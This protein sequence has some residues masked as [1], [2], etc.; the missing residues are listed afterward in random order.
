VH[1]V[2]L[3]TILK[4]ILSIEVAARGKKKYKFEERCVIKYMRDTKTNK[5]MACYRTFFK[6]FGILFSAITGEN[7][8]AFIIT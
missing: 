8:K 7:L 3:I 5:I 4:G 2:R 1:A 6:L